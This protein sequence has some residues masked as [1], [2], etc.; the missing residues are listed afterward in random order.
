MYQ[1]KRMFVRHIEENLIKYITVLIIFA[2]G[3][4]F[5]F[6]FSQNVSGSLSDE[7]KQEIG[8]LIAVIPETSV[9]KSAIFKNS[10]MKNLRYFI[11]LFAGGFSAFFLPLIFAALLSY[12][13]SMGF[14]IGYLSLYFGGQGLAL[15]VASVMFAFII[16]IPVYMILSVVALNNCRNRKYKDGNFG[17]YVLVFVFL[18]IISLISVGADAFIT[19]GIISVICS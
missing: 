16:N 5:G 2:I 3:I 7:L 9:D 6:F 11:L 19:P 10:F 15:T 17:A 8:D 18:F 12:G 4:A 13:F 1:I 14:T